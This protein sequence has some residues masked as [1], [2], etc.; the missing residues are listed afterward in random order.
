MSTMA[1]VP[2]LLVIFLCVALAAALFASCSPLA[3][4]NAGVP[5]DTYRAATDLAYGLDARQRLDVYRPADALSPAPVVVFFYGGNWNSGNRKDYLFVGE[6]LAAKGFV[7][8]VPDYRLYPQVR[9]PDFLADSAQAV[10]WIIDHI[11]EYGGDP[12]RVFVMG[13]SAGAYNAAM[14]AL[15][16]EYLK[17]A[18]VD[19]M[20]IRG[21][22]GL[23]GA[24][25]F[26]PLTGRV[27]G[28][29]FGYPETPVTTQPIHFASSASPP[30]L[31]ITGAEDDVVDPGNSV[32][33][34]ARLR[35]HGVFVR[36]IVYPKLGHRAL[37]GA[38]AAPLRSRYDPVLENISAFVN[39]LS[40]SR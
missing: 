26:L 3:I 40:A 15:N 13:H 32:R 39:E 34:G 2:S 35:E 18:G 4:V 10:R 1:R 22:I 33:L 16:P 24:Y 23:A 8:V 17:A 20:R 37:I 21:M 30:V 29:V 5:S 36:E 31:V 28:E 27:T 12:Q 25:D 6:A 7:A 19:P 11:A 9:F 38:L 14:L